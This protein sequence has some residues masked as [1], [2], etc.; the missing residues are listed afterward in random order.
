[1]V[2]LRAGCSRMR[3]R[4]RN[5]EALIREGGILTPSSRRSKSLSSTQKTAKRPRTPE[6]F[7]GHGKRS[8]CG[9][10]QACVTQLP[11]PF[12]IP[13]C[14]TNRWILRPRLGAQFRLVLEVW[15]RGH[16]RFNGRPRRISSGNNE[17]FECEPRIRLFSATA[18]TL[19]ICYEAGAPKCDA[20]RD[21]RQAIDLM[22]FSGSGVRYI[23]RPTISEALFSYRRAA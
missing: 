4:S 15:D 5:G 21:L 19:P 20:P 1:M 18:S 14:S 22:G 7:R 23:A 13:I 11:R 17:G 2:D 6:V 8:K 16:F 3:R 12:P 9:S 10:A